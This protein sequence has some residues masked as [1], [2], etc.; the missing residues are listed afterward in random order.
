MVP[1]LIERNNPKL[2]P[3]LTVEFLPL[4][5]LAQHNF[6]EFQ[7]IEYSLSSLQLVTRPF[8]AMPNAASF[9]HFLPCSTSN[10]F[11]P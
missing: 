3:E 8:Q 1:P 5:T 2:G 10:L 7:S 4:E 9:C 11:H 6:L